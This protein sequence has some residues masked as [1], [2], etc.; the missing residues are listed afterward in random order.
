[1]T[2]VAISEGEVAAD[3]QLTG[4]NYVLRTAKMVR[5]PD[6]GVA[7]AAGVFRTG[8]AGLKWLAEGERGEP[9]EI[10]GATIAIVR[11]DGTILLADDG[12]PAFP[13][14]ERTL[15]LGCGA[16]LARMAM[17]NGRSPVEAVADACELDANSSAPIMSMKAEQ[18]EFSPPAFHEVKRGKSP[19]RR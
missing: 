6:G 10:D 4:G 12:W 8:Y 18:V 7:V 13:L 9:P 3:T 1:V 14:M 17:A 11:P 5:L 2:T 16:D 19:R 15:A